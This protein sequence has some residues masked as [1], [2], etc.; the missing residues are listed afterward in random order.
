MEETKTSK[1]RETLELSLN[2]I[3]II[4]AGT[5]MVAKE[6]AELGAN[7]N[8]VQT[9]AYEGLINRENNQTKKDKESKK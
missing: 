8:F 1:E 7:I 9:L 2:N 3:K 6:H 5:K 4:V